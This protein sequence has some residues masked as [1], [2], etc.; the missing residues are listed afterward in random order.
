MTLDVEAFALWKQEHRKPAEAPVASL[1]SDADLVATV[2]AAVDEANLMVSKAESVRRFTILTGQFAV[3]DELTPTQKVRR[4][5]VLT[6]FAEEIDDMY[7]GR[8]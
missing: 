2:Q 7:A 4:A 8:A 1:R 5:Y 3:S 6:K